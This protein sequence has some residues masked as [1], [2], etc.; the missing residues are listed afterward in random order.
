MDGAEVAV[1]CLCSARSCA[2]CWP[3]CP[4]SELADGHRGECDYR[5]M[6]EVMEQLDAAR[7]ALLDEDDKLVGRVK[8]KEEVEKRLRHKL[9]PRNAWRLI[10]FFELFMSSPKDELHQWLVPCMHW[11][12]RYIRVCTWCVLVCTSMY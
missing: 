10:P 1:N 8:D 5:R 6:A 4:D 12:M 3:G 7:D 11:Y 9:L 2:T